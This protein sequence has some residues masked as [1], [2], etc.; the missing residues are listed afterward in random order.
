MGSLKTILQ[1]III[2]LAMSSA[3]NPAF[4]RA[5]EPQDPLKFFAACAGRLS[6]EM[7]FQWMFDGDAADAFAAER[8]AVL[9]ILEAMMSDDQGRDVLNWR[10]EAKMAQAALL[11]RATFTNDARA[12]RHSA[13]LALYNVESCR[14]M[15][16]S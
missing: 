3:G 14:A 5:P 2:A 6:A 13:K 15:L 11:T 10:V 12:A 8:A 16:L 1:S 4:A 9:D 7:E